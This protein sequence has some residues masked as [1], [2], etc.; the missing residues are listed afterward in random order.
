MGVGDFVRCG[1]P[2]VHAV[3][4][5]RERPDPAPRRK[6][7]RLNDIS[8]PLYPEQAGTEASVPQ[9]TTGAR[10]SVRRANPMAADATAM[11]KAAI[12]TT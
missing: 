10:C 5:S 8:A 7:R 6:V 2:S 1:D 4:T 12:P 9:D 11:M 3:I